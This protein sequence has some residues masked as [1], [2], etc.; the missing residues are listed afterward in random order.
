M[1]RYS[2]RRYDHITAAKQCL[3]CKPSITDAAVCRQM[4]NADAVLD[5]DGVDNHAKFELPMPAVA[6]PSLLISLI[7][8][9]SLFAYWLPCM[10]QYFVP[11]F[12]RH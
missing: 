9:N 5:L 12:E 1:L 6:V 4:D 11:K 10:V 8:P 7:Y 3:Y 2:L